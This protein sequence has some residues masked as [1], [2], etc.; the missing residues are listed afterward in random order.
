MVTLWAFLM[1]AILFLC[2]VS[3]LAAMAV[4]GVYRWLKINE[5]PTFKKPAKT[6]QHSLQAILAVI[7][8]VRAYP[9]DTALYASGREAGS[10]L[11]ISSRL[12]TDR[13]KLEI[14]CSIITPNGA[15][16]F[17]VLSIISA[18]FSNN[19]MEKI[20]RIVMMVIATLPYNSLYV[21]RH[22]VC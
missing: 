12:H 11:L 18:V 20:S 13:C 15:S 22:T 9:A 3:G 8:A 4:Y 10:N 16:L 5:K 21:K 6:E 17:T 1:P 2:A 19:A 7:M 14:P